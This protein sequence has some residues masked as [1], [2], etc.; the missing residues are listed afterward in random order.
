MKS[1]EGF[2]SLA[3]G[4]RSAQQE[5]AKALADNLNSAARPQLDREGWGIAK[6][7]SLVGG[8]I[9]AMGGVVVSGS[10]TASG[11]G[12][13]YSGNTPD[14]NGA[15]EHDDPNDGDGVPGTAPTS[16]GE[17]MSAGNRPNEDSD[18]DKEHAEP[19]TYTTGPATITRYPDGTV[20]SEVNSGKKRSFATV[21]DKDVL[22]LGEANVLSDGRVEKTSNALIG[23]GMQET[24]TIYSPDGEMLSQTIMARRNSPPEIRSA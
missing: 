12:S 10:G 8:A 1:L 20:Y 11:P 2:Q 16:G 4:I 18:K 6:G 3:D 17:N 7:G 9:R 21:R 23:G 13:G 24:K 15:P 14:I 5:N 19:V 22:T